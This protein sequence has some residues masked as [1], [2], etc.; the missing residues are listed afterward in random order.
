MGMYSIFLNL[1][2]YT[3]FPS[4]TISLEQLL[5][6]NSY[7]QPLLSKTSQVSR[8][9]LQPVIFPVF[10]ISIP[11][12]GSGRPC[13]LRLLA[14]NPHLKDKLTVLPP[15]QFTEFYY[16]QFDQDRKALAPLYVSDKTF[17]EKDSANSFQA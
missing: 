6:A 2:P 1:L 8:I 3:C 11:W 12:L 13:I 5:T 17:Q 14:S 7:C 15:E 16:N 4:S 9:I 10:E